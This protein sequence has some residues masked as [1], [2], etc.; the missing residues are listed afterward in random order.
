MNC[1]N[2]NKWN[3]KL[4]RFVNFEM[5]SPLVKIQVIIGEVRG[6][7]PKTYNMYTCLKG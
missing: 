4:N 5:C 7:I 6:S 2:V 1:S 3:K